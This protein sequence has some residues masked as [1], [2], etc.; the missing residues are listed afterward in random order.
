MASTAVCWAIFKMS[1][2]EGNQGESKVKPGNSK[3][4]QGYS[5]IKQGDSDQREG[6]LV[7][8][9]EYKLIRWGYKL[10]Y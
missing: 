7:N 6:R 3:I 4:Q 10:L 2:E 1:A 8:V 9:R 5:N